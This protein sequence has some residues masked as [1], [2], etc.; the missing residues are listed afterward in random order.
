MKKKMKKEEA[1]KNNMIF[2]K[3]ETVV[4]RIIYKNTLNV[5]TTPV[6]C[7]GTRTSVKKS[8]N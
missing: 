3:N 7:G 5:A 1:C 2:S 6:A 8:E 4:L